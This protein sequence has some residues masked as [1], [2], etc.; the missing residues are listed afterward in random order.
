MNIPISC[1]TYRT[2]AKWYQY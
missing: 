1:Y 2:C